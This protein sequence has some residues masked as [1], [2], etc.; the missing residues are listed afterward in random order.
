MIKIAFCDDS[1]TERS[2]LKKAVKGI[3]DEIK[4]DP[5]FILFMDNIGAILADKGKNDYEISAMLA[6]A[7]ENG[8]IDIN[9]FGYKYSDSLN[10]SVILVNHIF[11]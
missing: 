6:R 3:L 2:I 11:V 4:A 8:E 5:Q 9:L 7:L 1:N 10:S